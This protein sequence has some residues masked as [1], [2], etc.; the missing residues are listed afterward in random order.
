MSLEQAVSA[1]FATRQLADLGA[2][3]VKI[4]R[5]QD[6]DFARNYDHTVKG[7][8]SHFVWLNR[9]KKSLTLDI[10]HRSAAAVLER[11]LAHADVLVQNLAPGA[12]DRAGL[13]S[14][15]L[16]RRFPRLIQCNISGYGRGG[17]LSDKKAYDLLVQC[18]TGLVSTTG[19]E[20]SMAKVGISIADIAAGMYAYSGILTALYERE[21]TG[22]GTVLDVSMFDCLGEW[23]GYPA[24]YTGYGGV[25]P[26]R[27]GLNHATIAPYGPYRAGDD[28]L[29]MLGIQNER[30]WEAFC[31]GVLGRDDLAK[32]DRFAS[33]TLRVAHREDLDSLIDRVF[34][35][36]SSD[37]VMR[38]LDAAKIANARI[39]S[40]QEFWDHAQ[41]KARDRWRSIGSPAGPLRALLP[42]VALRGYDVRMGS[43]P[44]LGEHNHEIL[45]ALGYSDA[46]IR[47]LEADGVI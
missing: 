10:K 23:M 34:R 11:L 12:A 36:L 20:A 9:S 31:H 28:R 21:K 7:M 16:S 29:V 43:V 33:N 45:L 44:E 2:S 22:R 14:D 8:S 5:P 37:E 40:M 27:T 46:D 15:L 19:T 35:T 25:A 47:R 38:R 26:P 24:Y 6:G 13:N 1:P 17:P 30:E 18:E 3:V 42:P 4:E 39:N 32:D 41:L